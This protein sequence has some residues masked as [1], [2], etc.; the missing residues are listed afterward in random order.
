MI[1]THQLSGESKRVA[2]GFLSAA[3]VTYGKV[4]R[5]TNLAHQTLANLRLPLID[6]IAVNWLACFN[7]KRKQRDFLQEKWS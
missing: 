2:P 7:Q 5:R 4:K 3:V 1:D 6:S